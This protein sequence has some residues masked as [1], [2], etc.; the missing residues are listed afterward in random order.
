MSIFEKATRLKLRVPT[1]QGLLSV[2]QLWTASKTSLIDAEEALVQTVE[3]YGKTTRR[4]QTAKS[5]EQKR[6]EL[7]LELVSYILDVREQEET[8]ATDK[9]AKKEHNDKIMAIIL[10]KQEA[11]LETMS[12]EELKKLMKD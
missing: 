1:A 6:N 3:A 8:S 2:E 7:C 5:E 9:A 4:K 10:R 12:A 11:E